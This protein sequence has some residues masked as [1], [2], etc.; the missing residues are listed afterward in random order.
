MLYLVSHVGLEAEFL[1]AL[2]MGAAK[3]QEIVDPRRLLVSL[4][5]AAQQLARDAKYLRRSHKTPEGGW[6]CE[7]AQA[8]F[9]ACVIHAFELRKLAEQLARASLTKAERVQRTISAN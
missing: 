1:D 8:E 7:E 2:S 5:F 6:D 4:D 3:A 9:A